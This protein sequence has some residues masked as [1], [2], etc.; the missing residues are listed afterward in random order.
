[1]ARLVLLIEGCFLILGSFLVL[2]WVSPAGYGM[3]RQLGWE[4]AP[5]GP[6]DVAMIAS[7]LFA[8][9]FVFAGGYTLQRFVSGI[10][11]AVVGGVYDQRQGQTRSMLAWGIFGYL[12]VAAMFG[13]FVLVVVE[14]SG[15]FDR[16]MDPQFLRL[17]LT[18]PYHVM[19]SLALFGVP[20]QEFY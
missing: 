20:T 14:G 11:G 13:S 3:Q 9:G 4:F 19:A 12:L 6:R 8:G 15:Q 10:I 17:V 16:F 18:W 7:G 2:W 1:M 5:M